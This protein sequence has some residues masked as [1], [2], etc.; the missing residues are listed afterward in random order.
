MTASEDRLPVVLV[1]L[2][3]LGDRAVPALGGR[4]PTE[5]AATPVLD[6]LAN[7]GASGL[8]LPFGWGRAAT[9]DAV[10]WALLGYGALPFCG[11]AVLEARAAGIDLKPDDVV[12]LATLR[13]SEE[14]S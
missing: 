2:E 4:T 9:A 10:R 5:A 13:S 8:H 7:R 14:R 3:G 1:V 11:R 12:A 6:E